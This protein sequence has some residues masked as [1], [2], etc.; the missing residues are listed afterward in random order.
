MFL[1]FA[2]EVR[3]SSYEPLGVFW[4][5][6]LRTLLV[7]FAETVNGMKNWTSDSYSAHKSTPD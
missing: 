6:D 5:V 4:G 7:A 1:F 2:L 3:L